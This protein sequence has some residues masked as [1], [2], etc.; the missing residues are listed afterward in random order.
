[1][2]DI[3]T[4]LKYYSFRH[5]GSFTSLTFDEVTRRIHTWSAALG[6]ANQWTAPGTP[7]QF[8]EYSTL[9]A[10]ATSRWESTGLRLLCDLH[11]KLAPY[12]G[13][14]VMVEDANG[15]RRV[16]VMIS[17]GVAPQV[18]ELIGGENYVVHPEHEYTA[19]EPCK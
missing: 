15:R 3:N 5:G 17:Y 19:V 4:R 16:Q 9:L 11:P 1:M 13:R 12:M 6:V 18:V 14:R 10:I 8:A 2:I 7:E